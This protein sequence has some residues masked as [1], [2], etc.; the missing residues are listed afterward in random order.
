MKKSLVSLV[1]FIMLIMPCFM[2]MAFSLHG[3][4]A[5]AEETSFDEFEKQ[6]MKAYSNEDLSYLHL[7]KDVSA[8][9]LNKALGIEV[10][11]GAS[12]ALSCERM[13]YDQVKNI[14]N[15]N[16]YLVVEDIDGYN[17]R[18]KFS[19]KRILVN[20]EVKNTYNASTFITGYK[21]YN[22]L[23]YDTIEE[24]KYAYEQLLLDESLDVGL[25]AILSVSEEE[26]A[27]T[28]YD[29]S[30]YNSWGAE[31][32]DLGVYNE[33][34]ALN[35]IEEEKVVV[36]IDTGINTSHHLLKDRILKDTDGKYVGYSYYE[37]LYTYS[38]YAFEDDK[39]H[40]SHVS[41]TIAELTPSNVKILPIK[42]LNYEGKGSMSFSALALEKIYNTYLVNYDIV[43]ANLSLGAELDNQSSADYWKSICTE[44][45]QELKNR[46]IISVV[47]AGNES[48]DTAWFSPANVEDAAI[49]VSALMQN[50]T[51]YAFD[52][53]YSNYGQTIDICAPGTSIVSAYACRAD[54]P[55]PYVYARASGTSMAAP[56][57]AAVVALLCLDGLYYNDTVPN[58]TAEDIEKRLFDSAI[59]KG[60]TGKDIYYGHGM[61][62][63][64]NHN[65]AVEYTAEDCEVTYDGQYHNIKVNVLNTETYTITYGFTRGVYNITD[66]TKDDTF[67]NYTNGKKAVYF[68]ISAT[69]FATT[70]GVAYL[71]IKQVNLS[72]IISDQSFTYG[73][74]N[75][76]KT[77]YTLSGNV[78][79]GDSASF[80]LATNATNTSPVGSYQITLSC[81]NK[82][83]NVSSSS[84]KLTITKRPI[85]LTLLNQSFV[86]GNE[87]NLNLTKYSITSG[88]VVNSDNLGLRITTT[89]TSTSSVGT[90]PITLNSYT[91]S[92]YNIS[93]TNGTLN[94]TARPVSL[95][96]DTQSS[97]YG[98]AI[99]IDNTK[100]TITSGS[101]VEGDE[102][103]LNLST[104]ANSKSVGNYILKYNGASNTNYN[105]TAGNGIYKVEL[106]HVAFKCNDQTLTY[107]DVFVFDNDDYEI[108]S[109]SLLPEDNID[110]VLQTTATHTGEI[111]NY[112]I[113]LTIANPNYSFTVTKGKLS[114]LPRTLSLSIPKQEIVYGEDFDI[115]N[116][117]YT[118]KS[119]TI[120]N[121]DEVNISFSTTATSRSGAGTYQIRGISSNRNYAIELDND[122][123]TI[124]KRKIVIELV[125]S[126]TYGETVKCNGGEYKTIEG[127]VVNNDNLNISF[128]TTATNRSNVG[129]YEIKVSSAN[130][131]YD[132][133]L[134]KGIYTIT[135]RK[136]IITLI[137][138]DGTYGDQP[139]VKQG[140]YL[141][142]SGLLSG[143]NPE[144]TLSTTADSTSSVGSYPITA[145]SANE[146]Y[147]LQVR[148]ANYRIRKR[149]VTIRLLDQTIG[150]SFS[151]KYDD[152]AYEVVEGSI[153]NNDDLLLVVY[154]DA[155]TQALSGNYTLSAISENTN[156]NVTVISGTVEV[157]FSGVS[158]AI[159][160]LP[161]AL[162]ATAG[163][164]VYFMRRRHNRNKYLKD[165][166]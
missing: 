128:T 92:N 108:V 131:N 18:N 56:H 74:I 16:D 64:L 104:D 14:C 115:E 124:A 127:N 106:R 12:T 61:L 25:D 32:I 54:E 99:S 71:N 151:L 34:L 91:N 105:V 94:I 150:Y 107:G 65:I 17:I 102:L 58:Y 73:E 117:E 52:Y 77:K 122:T 154:S 80:T 93:V 72:A 96:L 142:T 2:L 63:L 120:I 69:D 47:S 143:D 82:N 135:P 144:L 21:D 36:V 90:Y 87:I 26:V 153:A 133:T 15:Q 114:V 95:T 55:D 148:S 101:L 45:F 157:L 112:E 136:L 49:V 84:G 66:Y 156:Y 138:Q 41:G 155:N 85:S 163:M 68:Q 46:R 24:T 159:V 67:K 60:E 147:D 152:N 89:A 103:G 8:N 50:G 20:G 43:C 11:E 139:R 130:S 70:V 30:G 83:Y 145:V 116:L 113:Y 5:H 121:N 42:V 62:S 98:D 86:Y 31:A 88:K 29:Y 27:E 6:I 110:I 44:V 111:G 97:M 51:D 165:D 38:G 23:C 79:A 39:G 123:L 53:S 125:Q 59:D 35:G 3:N 19:L 7:D 4:Y 134:S 48:K 166:L 132:V 158:F 161:I 13:N 109:G 9:E 75:L 149:D 100:Y 57:T 119:G 28:E 118:L 1:L 162:F 146:N 141:V 78:I 164:I 22:V 76:D 129:D 140:A 126:S 40:G 10:F 37:S 81:S 160:F 33:Y 137:S